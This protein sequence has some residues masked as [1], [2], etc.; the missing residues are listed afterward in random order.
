MPRNARPHILIVDD[1]SVVCEA[2]RAALG[3]DY[4]VHA[5]A[6]GGRACAVLRAR[7]IAAIVLDPVLGGEDGLA[8]VPR[9]RALNP[10]PIVVSGRRS[11]ALVVRALRAR[12]DDYLP[13]KPLDGPAL[14]AALDRLVAPHGWLDNPAIRARR[15][16]EAHP[17]SPGVTRGLASEV[18]VSEP[19][20]RRL[21]RQ[22]YGK[23]PRQYLVEIRLK[24]AQDLLQTT[25]LGVDR[26]ARAV[27]FA[28]PGIFVKQFKR[29]YRMTPVQYRA[30]L[31][32]R[33]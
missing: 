12:V 15:Y 29:I 32:R 2:V 28:S 30:T 26:I 18:G 25:S 24:R 14:R 31:T 22:T 6:T 11:E 27:G 33:P 8:L 13:K 7:P 5:A 16:L 4:V 9:L 21:F 20:V 23:T 19:H 10:V 3:E 1:E 17:T